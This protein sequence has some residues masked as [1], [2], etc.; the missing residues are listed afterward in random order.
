MPQDVELLVESTPESDSNW[1][2]RKDLHLTA[3]FKFTPTQF[4][5][6]SKTIE[7]DS[8]NWH[9][10]PIAPGISKMLATRLASEQAKATL[11]KGAH[12]FYY[13]KTSNGANLLK[14]SKRSEWLSSS[15]DVELA[16]LNADSAELKVF[17]KQ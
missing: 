8:A 6:Y 14:T 3:T 2:D 4:L 12:G 10:L 5:A 1:A 16:I 7:G 17:V 13:L 9:A 15:P 11:D